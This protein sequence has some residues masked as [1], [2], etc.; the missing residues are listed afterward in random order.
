MLIAM[1]REDRATM[2]VFISLKFVIKRY[3]EG[4]HIMLPDCSVSDK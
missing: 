1:S 2:V 4:G 3:F